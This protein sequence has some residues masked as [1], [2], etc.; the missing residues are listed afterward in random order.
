MSDMEQK[1]IDAMA[2]KVVEEFDSQALDAL[3]GEIWRPKTVE[4]KYMQ[5]KWRRE[6]YADWERV[7]RQAKDPVQKLRDEMKEE[8]RDIKRAVN[9]MGIMLDSEAPTEE[10][11]RKS[12]MLK[13]AYSKYK[14]VEKLVLGS[15]A[16]EK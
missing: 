1:I 13:E 11:L 4:R 3:T 6:L 9:K 10:Q 8:L 16:S 7:Q 14:M 15:E 12:K 2:R 5:D